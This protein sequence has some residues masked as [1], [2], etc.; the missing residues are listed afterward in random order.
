[1]VGGRDAILSGPAGGVVA[2]AAIAAARGLA[3]AIGFDMGGTSSDVCRIDRG[4]PERSWESRT[5]GVRVRAPM[6]AVHTIAAGGGSICRCDDGR[7][8]GGP[9]SVGAGPGPLCYGRAGASAASLTA[10]NLVLGRIGGDRFPPPPRRPPL[11]A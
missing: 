6:L 2:V 4:A 11:D 9:A 3:G 1:R 8:T 5:A 7:L 10:M